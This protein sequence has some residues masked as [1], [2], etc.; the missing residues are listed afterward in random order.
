MKNNESLY[1]DTYG[2]EQFGVEEANEGHGD[3]IAPDA[4]A[5]HEHSGVLVFRE[6]VEGARREETLCEKIMMV[7]IEKIIFG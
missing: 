7:C 4:S 1:H 3:K 2:A 6:V 5:H